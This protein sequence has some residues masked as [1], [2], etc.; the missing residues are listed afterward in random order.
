MALNIKNQKVEQLINEVIAITGENKTEAIL[1]ALRERKERLA[2]RISPRGRKNRK[3][4]FLKNEIWSKVP[5]DE[6]GKSMKKSEVEE[7]LGYGET[8]V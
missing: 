7:I 1:I 6:L 5:E 4:D 3:L 8:G 2:Y